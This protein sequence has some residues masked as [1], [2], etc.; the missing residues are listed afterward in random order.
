[1]NILVTGSSGF[2][3]THLIKELMK[4][5]AVTCYD[6]TNGNDIRNL[7][8]LDK[9]FETSQCSTVVHLAARAGVRRGNDYPH[10]YMTT[11]IEGTWNVG[12][13]CEK[14]GCRLISF[15]S[16]S[17]YG[18]AKP[19]T[20]EDDPKNPISL[21]GMTKL[22]GEHVVNQLTIPTVIIRPFTVYGENGRGDQ[23][24]YKW[25]NQYKAGKP[26]TVFGDG[27]SLRGYTYVKDIVWVIN[28]LIES[29]WNTLHDD[30]NIGG[31]EVMTLNNILNIFKNNTPTLKF[32]HVE[33]P[34]H[35]IKENYA[36]ISKATSKLGFM[37]LKKFSENLTSIINKE[38]H[39]A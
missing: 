34:N 39:Y 18:D 8:D 2:I 32:S 13:M 7:H 36:D 9:A 6:L 14:Y 31:R 15:S 27:D 23:V 30:F 29:K 21:Y 17:V 12:K 38:L 19:P 25:L 28:R 24:F 11:N 22:M 20:K 16:S 33:R 26:I 5:H 1:M 35:D 3:G 37:P 4:R 10:E